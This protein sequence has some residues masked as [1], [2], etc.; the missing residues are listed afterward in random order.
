MQKDIRVDGKEQ[1]PENEPTCIRCMC[2]H[3]IRACLCWLNEVL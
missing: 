2:V 3:G 1:E